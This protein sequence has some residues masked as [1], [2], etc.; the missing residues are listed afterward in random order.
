MGRGKTDKCCRCDTTTQPESDNII[1]I[2]RE[3]QACRCTPCYICVGTNFYGTICDHSEIVPFTKSTQFEIKSGYMLSVSCGNR[4]I[5]ILIKVEQDEYGECVLVLS[6]YELGYT[7]TDYGDT[8]LKHYFGTYDDACRL[9]TDEDIVFNVYDYDLGE[10][11]VTVTKADFLD[12]PMDNAE[13]GTTSD[14]YQCLCK[15]AAITRET[16][17]SNGNSVFK[18]VAACFKESEYTSEKGEWT[19]D[20]DNN[21]DVVEIWVESSDPYPLIFGLNA[22]YYL[23]S[24]LDPPETSLR[25]VRC[26]TPYDEEANMQAEWM[27]TQGPKPYKIYIE[28]DSH[29]H[30]YHCCKC[31]VR[32]LCLS[33]IKDGCFGRGIVCMS[34]QDEYNPTGRHWNYD[35]PCGSGYSVSGVITLI[36][37]C[38]DM[39]PHLMF[40]GDY[41]NAVR[42]EC[43]LFNNPDGGLVSY[44]REDGATINLKGANCRSCISADWPCCPGTDFKETIYLT[45]ISMNALCSCIHGQVVPM[46]LVNEIDG[47]VYYKASWNMPCVVEFQRPAI[48]RTYTFTTDCA[49]GGAVP[50]GVITIRYTQSDSPGLIF[51]PWIYDAIPSYE[52]PCDPLYL[53]YRANGDG[54]GAW[55][56]CEDDVQDPV[57]VEMELTS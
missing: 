14:P 35:V 6:S 24:I 29:F 23:P 3:E 33:V 4:S 54:Q 31:W 21:G 7:N 27:V 52:S 12:S 48:V 1:V 32:C 42:I 47:R 13:C 57:D 50:F 43:P 49:A 38:D 9:N 46:L 8:R 2:E 44:T 18:R 15:R 55:V 10:G 40:D 19:V 53:R 5:D 25:D 51:G 20:F 16:W 45:L 11:I 26:V 34:E 22:P 56:R 30:K 39:Q 17:D 28:S 37:K 36:C 41:K